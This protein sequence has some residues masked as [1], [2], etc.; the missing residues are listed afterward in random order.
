M[1][2]IFIFHSPSSNCSLWF[3][4]IEPLKCVIW[5]F[6]FTWRRV[7]KSSRFFPLRSIQVKQQFSIHGPWIL[8]LTHRGLYGVAVIDIKTIDRIEQGMKK[9]LNF[10][11]FKKCMGVFDLFWYIFTVAYS[12]I[13]SVPFTSSLLW[14]HIDTS[15]GCRVPIQV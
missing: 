11:S 10:K 6:Y 14:A 15:S 5:F 3:S 2:D 4:L 9:K 13:A 1:M 12:K 7:R 8:C